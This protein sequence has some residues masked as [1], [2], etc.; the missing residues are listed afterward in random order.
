MI[1]FIFITKNPT[2]VTFLYKV[3]FK[4]STST[5]HGITVYYFSFHSKLVFNLKFEGKLHGSK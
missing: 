1:K 5:C 3:K 4:Y 2:M